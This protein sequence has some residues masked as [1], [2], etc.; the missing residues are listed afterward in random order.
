M[1][2]V[3]KKGVLT[4]PLLKMIHIRWRKKDVGSHS[5][6]PFFK[7]ALRGWVR[8]RRGCHVVPMTE[9]EKPDPF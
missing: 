3:V 1:I 8:A 4:K 2:K 6:D 7:L 5:W 9:Q